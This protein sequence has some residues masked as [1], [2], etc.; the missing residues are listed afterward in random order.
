MFRMGSRNGRNA[1]QVE[2]FPIFRNGGLDNLIEPFTRNYFQK[3]KIIKT[4]LL[5]NIIK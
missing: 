2:R 5:E 4:E 3:L 1:S